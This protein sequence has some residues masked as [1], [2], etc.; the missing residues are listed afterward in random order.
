MWQLRRRIGSTVVQVTITE[1][2]SLSH[3][4]RCL[5]KPVVKFATWQVE[6]L[7][8]CLGYFCSWGAEAFTVYVQANQRRYKKESIPQPPRFWQ[9]PHHDIWYP[10][11]SFKR[12]RVGS[13]PQP[14]ILAVYNIRPEINWTKKKKRNKLRCAVSSTVYFWEP[15]FITWVF[16]DL[17]S[18]SKFFFTFFKRVGE[19][20]M[21][22]GL[23]RTPSILAQNSKLS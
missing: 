4:G 20:G 5:W 16:L 2:A 18:F 15:W 6:S 12:H 11:Y 14:E 22:G 13:H 17:P 21:A 9:R 23:E 8:P 1:G 7:T 19:G 10:I 3:G